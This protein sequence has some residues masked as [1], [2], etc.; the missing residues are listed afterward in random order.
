MVFRILSTKRRSNQYNINVKLPKRL[1]IVAIAPFLP[2]FLHVPALVLVFN[3]TVYTIDGFRPSAHGLLH[4]SA[5]V[6]PGFRHAL[7]VH[8]TDT[9]S[10]YDS[11][12]DL[13]VMWQWNITGRIVCPIPD[14]D[15][16]LHAHFRPLRRKIPPMITQFALSHGSMDLNAMTLFPIKMAAHVELG[17]PAKNLRNE[18][19]F[20]ATNARQDD[21]CSLQYIER[22][23]L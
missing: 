15:F 13:T 7:L 5:M 17:W 18:A 19:A 22:A 3:S 11:S 1:R 9:M 6:L 10:L 12:A 2:S 16:E 20:H 14:C 21:S 23:R 4:K 8:R